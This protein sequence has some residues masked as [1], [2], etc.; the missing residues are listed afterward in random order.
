MPRDPGKVILAGEN[1]FEIFDC[2]RPKLGRFSEFNG[3]PQKED[4]LIKGEAQP[5]TFTSFCYTAAEHLIGCS[6][7]GDLFVIKNIEVFQVID[8]M[9]LIA[10]GTP[11]GNRLQFKLVKA[12]HFGF[13]AATDDVLYFFQYRPPKEEADA[14]RG[15]YHCVLKW[16][17][18]EFKG[19]K[20]TA[21][22]VCESEE[23]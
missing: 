19:T 21:I 18:E 17:A 14:N 22:S 11:V 5:Q 23:C 20:I 3:T 2:N 6:N 13:V 4:Q 15:T 10:Q 1:M 16:R 7:L 8:S 12:N 9:S